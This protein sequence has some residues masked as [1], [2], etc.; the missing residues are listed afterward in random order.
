MDNEVLTHSHIYI[1]TA[2]R[3]RTCGAHMVEEDEAV[4][5]VYNTNF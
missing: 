3:M 5:F 2:Q 4:T 1:W